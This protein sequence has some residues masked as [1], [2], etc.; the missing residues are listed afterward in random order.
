MENYSLAQMLTM[1]NPDWVMEQLEQHLV[2]SELS[3][4]SDMPPW[5]MF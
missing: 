1:S 3:G 4:E 5:V 2:A